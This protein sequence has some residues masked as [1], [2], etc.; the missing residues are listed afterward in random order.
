[1]CHVGIILSIRAALSRNMP[2]PPAKLYVRTSRFAGE[3]LNLA[4]IG[5]PR[6]TFAERTREYFASARTLIATTHHITLLKPARSIFQ[7]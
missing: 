1:M 5:L 3:L 7:T 4:F 2:F 6:T